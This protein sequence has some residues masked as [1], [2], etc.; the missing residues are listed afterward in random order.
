[1]DIDLGNGNGFFDSF[2]KHRE[3]IFIRQVNG[4]SLAVTDA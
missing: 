1:M 3:T 4:T 2:L